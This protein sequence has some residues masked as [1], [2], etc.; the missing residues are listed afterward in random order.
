LKDPDKIKFLIDKCRLQ[1]SK[2]QMEIYRLYYKA[3]FNVAFR[4]VNQWADAEDVMQEAFIKAFKNIGQFKEDSSF[5]AWLRRIV[6]NES[7]R[8][9]NA[10]KK[11]YRDYL[12]EEEIEEMEEYI[13]EEEPNCNPEQIKA[14]KV[15][16]AMTK[17]NERYRIVLSLH[18]IEG[19]DYEEL[20][21]IL[22]INHGNIR[23]IVSRAKKKLK[24]I[25]KHEY[26]IYK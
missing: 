26:G 21:Q 18:L 7:L 3:M 4:I 17:L 19:F 11:S 15:I 22:K 16:Q 24:Q 13:Y 25:L 2:A 9:I 8:W 12:K 1:D 23:T 6:I 20:Q 10:Q 5:G 14:E